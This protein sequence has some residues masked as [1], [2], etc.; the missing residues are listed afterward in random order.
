[1]QEAAM[2]DPKMQQLIRD[3]EFQQTMM[4]LQVSNCCVTASTLA[5]RLAH[6]LP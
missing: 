6:R 4:S 1:M 3:P 5:V 2:K